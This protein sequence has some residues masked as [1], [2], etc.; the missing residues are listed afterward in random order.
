MAAIVS[1]PATSNF[2]EG[3]SRVFGRRIKDKP[4]E[5]TCNNCDKRLGFN[6]YTLVGRGPNAKTHRLCP[7]CYYRLCK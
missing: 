7:E 6:S 4:V 1:K 3:W 5:G 2:R